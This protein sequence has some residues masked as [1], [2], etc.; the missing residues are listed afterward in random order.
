MIHNRKTLLFFLLANTYIWLLWDTQVTP[1]DCPQ[2]RRF[3]IRYITFLPG[4][5][6][7]ITM[8]E[9][10]GSLSTITAVIRGSIPPMP[11]S[12]MPINKA[13]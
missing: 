7:K 13:V 11:Y 6:E 2:A 4:N 5:K 9:N 3:P 10:A 8:N 1:Y 12:L